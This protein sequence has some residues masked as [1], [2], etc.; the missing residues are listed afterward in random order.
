MPTPVLL[1]TRSLGEGGTE[2]QL[3]ELARSFDP[4]GFTPHIGCTIGTGFRADE[5]RRRG[6]SILELPMN[7]LLSRSAL[8]SIGRF[9]RYVRDNGI[10]LVHAF[11]A[12]MVVFGVPA[13]R[14]SSAKVVLSSQR[15]YEDTIFPPHRKYVRLAHRLAH[16]IV[17]NCDA[18]RQHLLDH[19]RVPES[20]IRV[21]H[22][23]L[24]TAVFHP[25]PR[26]RRAELEQASLVIGVVSVL[27]TE[28]NLPLLLEA[29]GAV[30]NATPGLRLLI[31]GGGP[32]ETGLRRL[33]ERLGIAGQCVFQPTTND[34]AAWLHA[35]DIFVLPS[36]SEALSNAIMEAMGCGCCVVA[37]RVGGNPEL[38]EEEKTGLLFESGDA[39]ALAEKLRLLIQQPQRRAEMAA[40]GAAWISTRFSI[41]TSAHRMQEIY[42]EFLNKHRK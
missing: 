37:S 6:L 29:F 11:D 34:V 35:I 8:E 1:L 15:C 25:G 10:A 7:S 14:L 26:R 31:V 20:K 18:M 2:R 40:A 24:D 23:G 38:V 5:L 33:S 42:D 16:G 13:G 36:R 39:D 12:P 3:S 9:R 41:Q 32:E 4:R 27:R 19:Y 30:R 21:C 22:N 17:A 28:K